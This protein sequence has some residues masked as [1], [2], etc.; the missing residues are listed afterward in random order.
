MMNYA[1]PYQLG[2]KAGRDIGYSMA[3]WPRLF[4]MRAISEILADGESLVSAGPALLSNEAFGGCK[5]HADLSGTGTA[6]GEASVSADVNTATDHRRQTGNVIGKIASAPVPRDIRQRGERE[7]NRLCW[8]CLPLACPQRHQ[9]R[10][11]QSA[12]LSLEC[13]G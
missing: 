7:V 10:S 4:S 3:D 8:K 5:V 12:S 2:G 11:A 9:Q 1:L 13:L 6:S